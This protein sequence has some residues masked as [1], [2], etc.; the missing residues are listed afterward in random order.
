MEQKQSRFLMDRKSLPV[1]LLIMEVCIAVLLVSGTTGCESMYY[2][3]G[4][5]YCL[6]FPVSI[7][8]YG[9]LFIARQQ[10]ERRLKRR[11][12]YNAIVFHRATVGLTLIPTLVLSLILGFNAQSISTT[13]FSQRYSYISI[14]L[15]LPF[16]I[17]GSLLGPLLGLVRAC[18]HYRGSLE[19]G[20][21]GVISVSRGDANN[22]GGKKGARRLK[23]KPSRDEDEII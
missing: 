16:L 6:L 12:L 9:G 2:A 23:V 7:F 14:L 5:F 13:F 1:F 3:A 19:D 17:F 11:R 22:D 18:S 8:L 4:P 20:T 21:H 15:L 10:I